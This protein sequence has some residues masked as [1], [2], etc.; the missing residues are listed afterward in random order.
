MI[1]G[2]AV[3]QGERLPSERGQAVPV[4]PDVTAVTRGIFMLSY[5]V[6]ACPSIGGANLYTLA[7]TRPVA[8]RAFF[9]CRN[10][11]GE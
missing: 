8:L 5:A 3:C 10:G 2:K 4:V 1:S 11:G 7:S 9:R 6:V